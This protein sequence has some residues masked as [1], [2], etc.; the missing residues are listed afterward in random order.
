MSDEARARFRQEV[1]AARDEVA[2]LA[3]ELVRIPSENP[4]GNTEAV[5]AF[6]EAFLAKSPDLS[7]RRATA[8]PTLVNIM[9][10]LAT[11]RPGRRLVM[12]AHLDTFPIGDAARWTVPPLGGVLKDGRLYGRGSSD[13]KAGLA[14]VLMVAR[15][16]ARRREALKG[17]LLLALVSDEET[18]GT[19]GTQ[20]VIA[21]D[22]DGRGD[23]MLSADA[24]APGVLR[25]GEKGQLWLEIKATGTSS[26]GAHVHLGVNAIERLM[27]AVQ[28]ITE[29]R[30]HV[31]PVPAA[32]RSA[33]MAASEVSERVSGKGETATL[34]SL[35]VNPG[36]ITGGTSVN[37]VPDAASARLDIR[38][39]PGLSVAEVVALARARI[40]GLEGITLDVLSSTEPNWTEPTHEIVRR[41]ADNA[42][43]ALGT[44]PASNMRPG[45]SDSRFYRLAGIPAVVYGLTPFGMGGPDEHVTISDLHAVFEVHAMTAFDYLRA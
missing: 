9:A 26:H 16:L 30:A 1:L 18:G 3:A 12:N 38:F 41:V 45:F 15:L 33:V 44:R 37:I 17:E 21:N 7:A 4:P 8:K 32:I 29:L 19:W 23:A 14:V 22:P 28:R 34:L 31:C 20:H 27:T 13:M 36:T 6:V 5:A 39:P 2:S 24:G 43:A 25:F 42:A 10:K 40:T 11:G 35:T